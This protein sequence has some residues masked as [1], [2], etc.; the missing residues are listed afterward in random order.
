MVGVLRDGRRTGSWTWYDAEGRREQSGT[1]KQDLED[2]R[3]TRFYASGA[4]EEEG[5]FRMGQRDGVWGRWYDD[6]SLAEGNAY[7]D[8]VVIWQG[9]SVAEGVKSAEDVEDRSVIYGRQLNIH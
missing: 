7:S 1:Y 9:Q 2:G 3:W 5:E 8:F 6:G 4:K